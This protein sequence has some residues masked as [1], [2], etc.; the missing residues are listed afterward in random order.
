MQVATLF[1][2]IEM[3]NNDLRGRNP[4]YSQAGKANLRKAADVD[5]QAMFIHR[6]ERRDFGAVVS[7]LSIDVVFDDWN[8]IPCSE[9][10]QLPA[11]RRIHRH[12]GGIL[13]TGHHVD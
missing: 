5:N 11:G 1:D 6:L 3:L 7:K 13:K 8:A 9:S 2:A 12:A 4:S 10:H